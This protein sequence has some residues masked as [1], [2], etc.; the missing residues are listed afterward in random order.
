MAYADYGFYLKEYR[1]NLKEAD[2]IR[3]SE[4]SSDIIDSKTDFII[5]KKGFDNIPEEL[6]ERIKKACC[7]VSE[8][9]YIGERGGAK[10]S[11]S[12]GDYSVTY[13]SGALTDEQ[14]T[15]NALITYIPDL[16]KLARWL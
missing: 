1:G 9:L 3:L 8:S 14:R 5:R 2:F 7:A 16:I 6:A 15:D 10:M 12:V 13:A 11:E 4:R